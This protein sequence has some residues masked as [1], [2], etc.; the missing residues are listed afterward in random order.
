MM[1]SAALWT[2]AVLLSTC[3]AA[4]QTSQ[5]LNGLP[6][7]E[8]AT[9]K[10]SAPITD[11]R[12][13]MS[14]GGDP[15]R[16]NYQGL[17][18]RLILARAYEMKDYQITG[19][20]WI[21]SERFDVTAKIPDGVARE[22]VPAMLRALITER[23]KL[24]S[25][26]DKKE[27][28]VYALGVAKGGIKLKEVEAPAQ[29]MGQVRMGMGHLETKGSLQAL[30]DFLSR[31]VDRPVLFLDTS[32]AVYDIKL[33]WTPE[34]GQGMMRGMGAMHAGNGEGGPAASTDSQAPSLFTAIQ[35]QLGLKL[36]SR[37]APVEMLVI[38]HLEKVPT[39]N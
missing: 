27:M 14:M 6:Q 39:E 25:H 32:K 36:E 7:F 23:F 8:V 17:S 19:P 33:D 11:G 38:D 5:T 2:S 21:D 3:M 35:E 30:A 37:K 26:S 31:M 4:G 15:G 22:L 16:I 12:V 24:A 13:M 34:P 1:R 18:M 20:D 10:Q 28:N 9:I 29:G